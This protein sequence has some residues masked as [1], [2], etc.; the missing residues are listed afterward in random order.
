M[1]DVTHCI[2]TVP[3]TSSLHQ[4]NTTRSSLLLPATL[5]TMGHDLLLDTDMV[6]SPKMQTCWGQA[7]MNIE[8][9]SRWL[10]SILPCSRVVFIC[11]QLIY[12]V[13]NYPECLHQL[14]LCSAL[15]LVPSLL[16]PSY[17]CTLHVPADVGA[18]VAS[19]GV[20]GGDV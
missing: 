10:R 7:P 13:T 2:F 5:M 20:V 15:P 1:Q 11:L 17:L 3:G 12:A 4:V 19:Q 18:H 16:L 6:V 9:C 14:V 8:C